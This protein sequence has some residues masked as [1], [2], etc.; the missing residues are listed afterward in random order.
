MS[1]DILKTTITLT[2]FHRKDVDIP[3]MSWPNILYQI[4]QGESIG[5]TEIVSTEPVPEDKVNDEL[6]AIGNDGSFF[7]DLSDEDSF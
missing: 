6:I 1:K 5:S 3:N 4:D 2:V 7:D